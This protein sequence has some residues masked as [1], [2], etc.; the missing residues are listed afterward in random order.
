[1][2]SILDCSFF[3]C[4]REDDENLPGKPSRVK[5]AN[6]EPRERRFVLQNMGAVTVFNHQPERDAH[7]VVWRGFLSM[8]GNEHLRIQV[9]VKEM[10]VQSSSV[11]E[12]CKLTKAICRRIETCRS[13]CDHSNVIKYYGCE[14]VLVSPYNKLLILMERTDQSLHELIHEDAAFAL[15]CTYHDLLKIFLGIISG[16][17]YLHE[18][19]GVIHFNLRPQNIMLLDRKDPKIAGIELALGSLNGSVEIKEIQG[20][21]YYMA[22]EICLLAGFV[23]EESQKVDTSVDVFSLGVIMWESVMCMRPNLLTEKYFLG[24]GPFIRMHSGWSSDLIQCYCPEPLRKLIEKCVRFDMEH[25]M[26]K[27]L[28]DASADYQ[29]PSLQEIAGCI[30]GMLKKSWVHKKPVGWNARA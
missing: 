2:Y 24:K 27:S 21:Q 1:M 11:E 25:F 23:R 13:K 20:C 15:K 29:R 4:F 10:K 17:Q 30:K 14:S 19:M 8:L 28:G 12:N 22:P 9:A 26:S 18:T 7:G 5:I 16:V 6:R 3:K